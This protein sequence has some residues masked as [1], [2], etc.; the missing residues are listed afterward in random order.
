MA[1]TPLELLTVI[2]A[3]ALITNASSVLILST[4]NRFARAV[5]RSRALAVQ[6]GRDEI[7]PFVRSTTATLY[8]LARRRTRFVARALMAFYVAVGSFAFGTFSGL[9]AIAI[10]HLGAEAAG[11]Y[12]NAVSLSAVTI[13]TLAITTGAF[14][15][16][17]ES[18]M[19]LRGLTIEAAQH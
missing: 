18:R 14:L 11:P 5:D 1:Q 4:S 6:V 9:L 2:A 3:P 17:L 7:D 8:A 10:E 19:T 13:G 16:L 12:L 15:L